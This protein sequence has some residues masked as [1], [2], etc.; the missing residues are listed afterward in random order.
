MCYHFVLDP[1]LSKCLQTYTCLLI[2]SQCK[3]NYCNEYSPL[4]TFVTA[5]EGCIHCHRVSLNSELI[6]WTNCWNF[7]AR[8]GYG[9]PIIPHLLHQQW[10]CSLTAESIFVALRSEGLSHYGNL[11]LKIIEIE[12]LSHNGNH[13]FQENNFLFSEYKQWLK[14]CLYHI[15]NMSIGRVFRPPF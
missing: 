6:Q 11:Y 2:V 5:G 9:T 10:W 3:W 4:C 14:G 1:S 15:H 7:K 12:G 13:C 8:N